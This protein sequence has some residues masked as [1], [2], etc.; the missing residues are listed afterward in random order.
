MGER[1]GR[2]EL[3]DSKVVMHSALDSCQ[4]IFFYRI[5]LN[6]EALPDGN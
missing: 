5:L 1:L 2:E 4:H 6:I 3:E